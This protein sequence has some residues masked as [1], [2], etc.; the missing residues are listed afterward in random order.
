M[1][2]NCFGSCPLNARSH[3]QKCL[4]LI[5]QKC[6]R[7]NFVISQFQKL[8][9]NLG[10]TG[11]LSW[12]YYDLWSWWSIFFQQIYKWILKQIKIN[13]LFIHSNQ[14]WILPQRETGN[15]IW[16]KY[17]SSQRYVLIWLQK[18]KKL[19][20]SQAANW[21]RNDQEQQIGNNLS[22]LLFKW[23]SFNIFCELVY[24]N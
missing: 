4:S 14:V 17:A 19:G 6:S 9:K 8:H 21:G 11:I 5:I 20:K 15:I 16:I 13:W 24:K 10:D 23:V 2:F 12:F 18:G 7:T 3:S 1:L 22:Q